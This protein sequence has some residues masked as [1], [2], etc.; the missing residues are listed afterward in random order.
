VGLYLPAVTQ[1]GARKIG[2]ASVARRPRCDWAPGAAAR[3]GAPP[4]FSGFDVGR[5]RPT[6]GS[7][8]VTRP[9]V[10]S[11]VAAPEAP[12]IASLTTP[13]PVALLAAAPATVATTSAAVAAAI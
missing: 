6:A 13:T 7:V 12:T 9:A 3:Y 5:Q 10:G 8:F 1:P 2:S 4:Q 11:T